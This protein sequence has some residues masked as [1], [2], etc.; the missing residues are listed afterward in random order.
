MVSARSRAYLSGSVSR[1]ILRF[2]GWGMD[3]DGDVGI[4]LK[5]SM[6]YFTGLC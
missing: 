5:S 1:R 6:V 2:A 4:N 3:K